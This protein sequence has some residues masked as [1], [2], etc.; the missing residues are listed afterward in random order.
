MTSQECFIR[1]V[2]IR[3]DVFLDCD[4]TRPRSLFVM[5]NGTS[6][7]LFIFRMCLFF[8]RSW[9][10]GYGFLLGGGGGGRRRRFCNWFLWHCEL[11]SVLM[12]MMMMLLLLLLLLMLLLL[13]V[14]TTVTQILTIGVLMIVVELVHLS[15]DFDDMEEM[16]CW[17]EVFLRIDDAV[18]P[19]Y[20]CC[21]CDG[22][23]LPID[24]V[25]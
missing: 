8:A 11:F 21:Y 5:Y 22:C 7:H 3:H 13:A 2:I 16:N 15:N 9:L 12:M 20:S 10:F 24:D 17:D 14:E 4:C 6:D 1:N 18:N 25:M 23:D 19:N